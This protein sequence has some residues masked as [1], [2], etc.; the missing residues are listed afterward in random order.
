MTA[1]DNPCYLCQ[2]RAFGCHSWCKEYIAYTQYRKALNQAQ[3]D[4]GLDVY[5]RD[6]YNKIQRGLRHGRK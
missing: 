5:E 6:R 2:R 1:P 3:Q 4:G